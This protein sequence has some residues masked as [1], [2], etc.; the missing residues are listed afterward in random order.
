MLLGPLVHFLCFE[1]NQG[2]TG[3][4]GKS[5]LTDIVGFVE[6]PDGKVLS[7]TETGTLMLWDE[8]SIKREI[9]KPG[10][11]PCHQGNIE[12]VILDGNTIITGGFDGF[13]RFWSFEALDASDAAVVDALEHVELEPITEIFLGDTVKVKGMIRGLGHWIVLDACGA[14]WKL[15]NSNFDCHQIMTF[16]SGGITAVATSPNKYV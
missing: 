1:Q 10:R 8:N 4:F 2:A 7:G 12:V 11:V 9:Y 16:H 6:L 3:K 15:D 5:E 14:L 13:I